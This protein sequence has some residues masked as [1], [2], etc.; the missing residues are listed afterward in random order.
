MRPCICCF[1]L[2]TTGLHLQ[3]L[4]SQDQ[5]QGQQQVSVQTDASH[6]SA[7][8]D[9]EVEQVAEQFRQD[10]MER[11]QATTTTEGQDERELFSLACAAPLTSVWRI[12]LCLAVG[13]DC[14]VVVSGG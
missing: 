6:D 2:L 3:S 11:V 8:D 4:G 5:E 9:A 7:E 13:L 12:P 10:H 1:A 14:S